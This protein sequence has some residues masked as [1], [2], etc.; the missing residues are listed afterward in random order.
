MGNPAIVGTVTLKDA[1]SLVTRAQEHMALGEYPKA[2]VF[3]QTA[4][5]LSPEDP[6]VLKMLAAAAF[7][8]N[9]AVLAANTC[10]ATL[11][12]D[13]TDMDAQLG[14]ARALFILNRLPDA[15]AACRIVVA[16]PSI[17]L[18]QREAAR[19]ILKRI[20]L[21]DQERKPDTIFPVIS[22]D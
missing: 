6:G 9:D 13:P 12:L 4:A 19:K 11:C 10:E 17:S 8:N 16:S 2:I 14:L 7:Q 18:P 20:P 1:P 22:A 5:R 15:A 3:L 21:A